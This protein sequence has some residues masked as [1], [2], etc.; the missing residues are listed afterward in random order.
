MSLSCGGGGGEGSRSQQN[1]PTNKRETLKATKT[2]FFGRGQADYRFARADVEL[3][4]REKRKMS[5]FN[6][7]DFISRKCLPWDQKKGHFFHRKY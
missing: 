2:F 7:L 5:A 6:Y 4:P 3:S 1:V